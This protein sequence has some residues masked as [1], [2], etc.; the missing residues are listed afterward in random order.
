MNKLHFTQTAKK[1]RKRIDVKYRGTGKGAF[2]VC[3][4]MAKICRYMIDV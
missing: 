4:Y 1:K 3:G 2:L